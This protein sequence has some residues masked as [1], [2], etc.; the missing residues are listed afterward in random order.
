MKHTFVHENKNLDLKKNN[1]LAIKAP[2]NSKFHLKLEPTLSLI[3]FGAIRF[4]VEI[5]VSLK[6]V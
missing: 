1:S 4:F 3:I 5:W 2:A 6:K